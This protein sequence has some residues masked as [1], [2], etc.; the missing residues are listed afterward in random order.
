MNYSY[1]KIN[2]PMVNPQGISMYKPVSMKRTKFVWAKMQ[3]RIH[4]IQHK[5][6]GIMGEAA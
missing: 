4:E 3:Q 6:E 5:L 2:K 1:N